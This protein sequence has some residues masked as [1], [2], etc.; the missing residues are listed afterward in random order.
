MESKLAY[1]TQRDVTNPENANV[2]YISDPRNEVDDRLDNA[3]QPQCVI[4]LQRNVA[5]RMMYWKRRI[6]SIPILTCKRDVNGALN[7]ITVWAKGIAYLGCMYAIFI[8]M[9]HAQFSGCRTTPANWGIVSIVRTQYVSAY[10]S[11]DDY[12]DGAFLEP[13]RGLRHWQDVS[14]WGDSLMR[15][16]WAKVLRCAKRDIEG[17]DAAKILLRGIVVCTDTETF[18]APLGK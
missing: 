1:V 16:L 10:C 15:R 5:R 14:V 2:R 17:N 13:C 11:R 9:Y 7:L 8:A 12:I 4:P 18:A 6:P 3:R